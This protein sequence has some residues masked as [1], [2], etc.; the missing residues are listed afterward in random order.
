MLALL[1][2][3]SALGFAQDDSK[4]M[5]LDPGNEWQ[6]EMS[7]GGTMTIRIAGAE[8]FKGVDCVVVES[9]M[10]EQ[11]S[12]EVMAMTA[13]GLQS[14]K[15]SQGGQSMDYEKPILRLK[16]PYRE[17]DAWQVEMKAGL[18]TLTQKFRN[19]GAETVKVKAGAFD[20]L[21]VSTTIDT[22]QGKMVL[23]NWYARGVGLVKQTMEMNGQSVSAELSKSNLKP[24]KGRS[25]I[26]EYAKNLEKYESKDGRVMLFRPKEW[27]VEEGAM[28]GEGTYAVTVLSPDEAGGVM[29]ITF[30]HAEKLKDSVEIATALLSNLKKTYPDLDVAKMTSAPDRGRTTAE[31]SL[32]D[33]GNK[34]AGHFHFF[35]TP[36]A[37]TVFA[38][39][40][41]EK[42]W[43]GMRPLLVTIASNIA[44]APEG[45]KGVLQKGREMAT[46][47]PKPKFE[48]LKTPAAMIKA[49][50]EVDTR[51]TPMEKVTAQD[52]SFTMEVPRGWS[53]EG[54]TLVWKAYSDRN[55]SAGYIGVAHEILLPG[56]IQ[57]QGMLT[58]PYLP[59][60]Q[61]LD[62]LLRH[63]G[64]GKDVKIV[65]ESGAEAVDPG[66]MDQYRS[67]Q[68][69]GCQIDVRFFHVSFSG[70]GGQA[71]RG[72]FAVVCVTFPMGMAW[73]ASLFGG[74]SPDADFDRFLPV[75][76]RME[77]SVR[78]N[79]EW[80]N[81]KFSEQRQALAQSQ[82]NLMNSM[83][84]LR[85]SYDRYNESY[86]ERQRSRDYS[87]WAYSQSTLGQG[88]WVSEREGAE[89]VRT[90]SWGMSDLPSGRRYDGPEYNYANVTGVQR[91]G[92]WLKE[93]NTRDEYEKYIRNR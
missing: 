6:Y 92:E 39:M 64:L 42:Q 78:K 81:A 87:M 61:A 88:H 71:S 40:A 32:T 59:P 21:K 83:S 51:E 84:E 60:P 56:G 46:A 23:M 7:N 85:Q 86:W 53:F 2:S 41:K 24:S 82:R 8:K 31:V 79:D 89:V 67:L 30:D 57:V 18:Q 3:A 44:Y 77:K 49:A 19:E 75:C 47:G 50:K 91:N 10:G 13:E 35:H 74:Y 93:V 37:A 33:G 29:F 4:F 20:C 52:N 9:R 68:A 66:A 17:G 63:E 1:A 62:M 22:P 36:R 55:R 26:P 12:R 38:L 14:F 11:A 45:I 90:D 54:A 25:E 43:E 27:K 28:F 72:L 69:Q 65:S 76:M 5:P 73:S 48:D 16:L 34:F 80:T 70:P 58:S 15:F